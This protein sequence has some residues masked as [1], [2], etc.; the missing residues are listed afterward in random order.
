MSASSDRNL[1]SKKDSPEIPPLEW[2]IGALGL[3]IV[4]A[5]LGVLI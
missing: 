5:V 2:V 4:T 1:P 3:A